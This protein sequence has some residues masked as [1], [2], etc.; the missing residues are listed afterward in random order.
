[1]FEPRRVTSDFWVSP[2]IAAEDM[3]AAAA[4]GVRTVI[5]NRP[6]HEQPGQPS[7]DELRQAAE[8][9]GLAYVEL[10]IRGAPDMAAVQAMDTAIAQAQAPALAFCASGTRSILCW[11]QMMVTRGEKP[12]TEVVALAR[13][14]GYDLSRWF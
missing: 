12:S 9:A 2:Q 4:A 14:A 1:M 6:D 10:P 8:A 7:A 5:N 11:S 3:A 13:N